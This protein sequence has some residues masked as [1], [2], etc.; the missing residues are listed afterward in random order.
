MIPQRHASLLLVDDSPEDRET[1]KAYLRDLE[2]LSFNLLE[3]ED[4]E[5]GLET[6]RKVTVDCILLD[7]HLPAMDGL[8]F[9]EILR[10]LHADSSGREPAVVMITG[11]GSEDV[12]VAALKRGAADYIVKSQIGRESLH[13][14]V[15][16]ALERRRLT[17]RTA[18]AERERRR[19]EMELREERERLELLMEG[20]R[21]YAIVMFDETGLVRR[22]NRGAR[23]AFRRAESEVVGFHLD[24]LYAPEARE[25]GAPRKDLDR[26][27][28]D[29]VAPLDKEF[30][31]ADGTR[32]RASGTLR[33][34]SDAL[35]SPHGFV[36]VLKET[37]EGPT[38]LPEG[39]R[40]RARAA[41]DAVHAALREMDGK[42]TAKDAPGR[43][44]HEGKARGA[45]VAAEEAL[46][47]FLAA[48]A[49]P[50]GGPK[51][52]EGI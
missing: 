2:G 10:S 18:L 19:S 27:R 26:A 6:C 45:L 52:R 8:R 29:G 11:R 39:F 3:A 43:T 38:T 49:G 17:E 35:G 40:L 48:A 42:E 51:P 28:N 46:A 9:L 1:Y 50:R 34:L 7:Y 13:R 20:A 33:P 23:D 24:S 15:L 31:R 44:E 47:E 25:A 4:A 32:F 5:E 21:D 12:A 16:N 22:W 41:H 14:A 37:G 36:L 30:L